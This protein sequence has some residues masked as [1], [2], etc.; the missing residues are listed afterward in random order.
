MICRVRYSSFIFSLFCTVKMLINISI[1]EIFKC[2]LISYFK[3]IRI[4]TL[5]YMKPEP[6]ICY[7]IKITV[8]ESELVHFFPKNRNCY[9]RIILSPENLTGGIIQCLESVCD[10]L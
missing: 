7:V 6:H 8:I 2:N 5:I 10:F 1:I 4:G 3:L 9:N